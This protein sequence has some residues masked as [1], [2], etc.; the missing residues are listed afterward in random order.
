MKYPLISLLSLHV[1]NLPTRDIFLFQH[2]RLHD[3]QI[4]YMYISRS[5]ISCDFF[6]LINTV[7]GSSFEL[8][9][10]VP[11]IQILQMCNEVLNYKSNKTQRTKIRYT[12][13]S[14]LT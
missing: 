7:L 9:G 14:N 10:V 12:C 6:P 5:C 2:I 3:V 4:I 1:S 13:I 11:F 8:F